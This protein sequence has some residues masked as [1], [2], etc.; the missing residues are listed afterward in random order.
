M[1]TTVR[2][3]PSHYEVLGLT[4]AAS[5]QEIAQAFARKMSLFRARPL[6]DVAQATAAY[7]TLRNPEKRREYDRSLEPKAEPKPE[8]LRWSFALAQP[9]WK[10]FIT[11]VQT[12]PMVTQPAKV[13]Q[14][15]EPYVTTEPEPEAMPDPRV[16]SIAASLRQLAKPGSS[17]AP[18]AVGQ[19]PEPVRPAGSVERKLDLGAETP[20][21]PEHKSD[22]GVEQLIQ[23]IRIAGR[24]EKESLRDGEQRGPDWKRPVFAAGG[25]ILGVGILGGIAGVS[26]GGAAHDSVTVAIPAAKPAQ[27]VAETAVV[28]IQAAIEAQAGRPI[29]TQVAAARTPRTHSLP[30]PGF[31]E[32]ELVQLSPAVASAPAETADLASEP[33]AARAI[34][35]SLPLPN[36][37]IAR[38]IDRIGYSCGSVAQ[39][40]A[41]DGQG[42]FKITCSSGQSY[43]AAPVGGRYHFRRWGRH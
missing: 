2:P 7:E 30:K 1:V 12:N 17:E 29:R 18:G 16:A 43:Q 40:T 32:N 35:A 28:P 19:Q 13:A 24:A 14:A 41:V 26:A 34:P 38:T 33:A 4:P 31:A 25:L 21:R 8:P 22:A 37:V 6:A 42:A 39:A 27:R 9:A 36:H 3:R 23:Q 10:P 11:S 5:E 20:R 15:P